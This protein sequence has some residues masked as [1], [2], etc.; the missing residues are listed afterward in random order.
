M[1]IQ[2]LFEEIKKSNGAIATD[3]KDHDKQIHLDFM[4]TYFRLIQTK[5]FDVLNKCSRYPTLEPGD[6]NED[7][8]SAQIG[9]TNK[10]NITDDHGP[11]NPAPPKRLEL[12]CNPIDSLDQM[13]QDA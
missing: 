7:R 10:R 5:C 4:A 11:S 9:E 8:S 2:K 6:G 12:R 1:G 3:L 13:I